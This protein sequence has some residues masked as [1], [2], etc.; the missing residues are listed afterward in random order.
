MPPNPAPKEVTVRL[1]SATAIPFNSRDTLYELTELLIP[2][3]DGQVVV[4]D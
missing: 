3:L 4:I 2:A 1:L